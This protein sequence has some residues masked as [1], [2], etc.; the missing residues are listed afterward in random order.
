MKSL[1][2]T[3][4]SV[5][6]NSQRTSTLYFK[7]ALIG[8]MGALSAAVPAKDSLQNRGT[9]T[10]DGSA[11]LA[12]SERTKTRSRRRT[13][14]ELFDFLLLLQRLRFLDQLYLVLRDAQR[15]GVQRHATR[16]KR[17]PCVRVY[18]VLF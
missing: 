18:G 17:S 14:D 15:G 13:S 11:H 1:C 7:T 10:L 16:S 6:M 5:Q 9:K 12:E 4:T 2:G 8:M 3:G